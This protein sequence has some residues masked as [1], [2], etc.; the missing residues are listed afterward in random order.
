MIDSSLSVILFS[1]NPKAGTMLA[2][3]KA[4]NTQLYLI[5]DVT[6][7]LHIGRA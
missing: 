1:A 6:H 3:V 4:F 5:N 7:S 2:L